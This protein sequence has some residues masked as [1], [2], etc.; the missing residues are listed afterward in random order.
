MY[1]CQFPVEGGGEMGAKGGNKD[2]TK[3]AHQAK[4]KKDAKNK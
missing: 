4:N 3:S 2:K 1:L